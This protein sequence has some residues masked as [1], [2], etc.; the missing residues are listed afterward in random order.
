MFR[1]IYKAITLVVLGA[2]TLLPS[3]AGHSQGMTLALAGHAAP[4]AWNRPRFDDSRSDSS[5]SAHSEHR[6]PTEFVAPPHTSKEKAF[7]SDTGG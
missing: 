1:V 2:C 3:G 7:P 4:S 5:A 6:G